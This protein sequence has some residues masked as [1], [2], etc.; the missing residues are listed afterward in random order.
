[1]SKNTRDKQT[2]NYTICLLYKNT[3]T[4]E[5]TLLYNTIIMSIYIVRELRFDKNIAFLGLCSFQSGVTFVWKEITFDA[6]NLGH[7]QN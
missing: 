1:M 5:D 2:I 7:K 4:L 6:S 3:W